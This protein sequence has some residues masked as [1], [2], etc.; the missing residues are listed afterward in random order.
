MTVWAIA[1]LFF[2]YKLNENSEIAKDIRKYRELFEE[3][4][5]DIPDNGQVKIFIKYMP[6]QF[7]HVLLGYVAKEDFEPNKN[8]IE[9]APGELEKTAEELKPKLED[10]CKQNNIK[11]EQKDPKFYL[12]ADAFD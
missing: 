6:D 2:G 3:T 8:L 7:R 4:Q 9:I 12:L 11:I 10:F 1:K 5:K